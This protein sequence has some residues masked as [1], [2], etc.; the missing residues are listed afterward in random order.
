MSSFALRDDPRVTM[1]F[2]RKTFVG[3]EE[4][5]YDN[6]ASVQKAHMG[7][8]LLV[9]SCVLVVKAAAQG[10]SMGPVAGRRRSNPALAHRIPVQ[11]ITGAYF[12]GWQVRRVRHGA[13]VL[14]NDAF[15]AY[16][17]EYGIFQRQRRP[18]L[19]D[20]IIDMLR[21]VQTTRTGDMFV[22]WILGPRRDPRGR[23]RSF[24]RRLGLSLR[25]HGVREVSSHIAGP[26]ARLPR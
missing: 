14:Y 1:R 12:A 5:I 19:K 13:W 18:V 2:T 9:R 3:I 21:L 11:R 15:E 8:D 16:L 4:F 22:D 23:F 6:N 20:S 26:Q 7:F 17:I 24:E 25:T 10:R